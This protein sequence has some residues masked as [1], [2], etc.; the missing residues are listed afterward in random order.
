MFGGV[1]FLVHQQSWWVVAA[2]VAIY[3]AGID[4]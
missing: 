2:S 4:L 1:L 3:A